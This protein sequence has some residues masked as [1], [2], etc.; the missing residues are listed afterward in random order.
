[1]E[2]PKGSAWITKSH[3]V[4]SLFAV[5]GWAAYFYRSNSTEKT[6]ERIV[7]K[8]R[9]VFKDKIVFKDKVIL[10]DKVVLKD[11]VK[12]VRK[13]DG[14]TIV[15]ITKVGVT[16]GLKTKE[17]SAEREQALEKEHT[18]EKEVVSVKPHTQ[19]NY[20]FGGSYIFDYRHPL[21][22]EYELEYS[23]RLWITPVWG[24]VAVDTN[25]Y[26]SLGIRWEL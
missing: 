14:T 17:Q 8:D 24:R 5:S 25:R 16:E 23:Q 12:T 7:F 10:K 11:V 2:E 3:L 1:M 21:K 6:S 22:K 13:P 18:E 9:E 4:L 15:T 20:A 19:S 26:I